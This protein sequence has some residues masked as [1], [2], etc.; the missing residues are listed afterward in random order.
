MAGDKCSEWKT[1]NF[2]RRSPV[3][4]NIPVTVEKFSLIDVSHPYSETCV[5]V[6]FHFISVHK[7][8]SILY[9]VQRKLLKQKEFQL[10]SRFTQNPPKS[11][12]FEDNEMNKTRSVSQKDVGIQLNEKDITTVSYLKGTVVS[13]ERKEGGDEVVK[14]LK[15]AAVSRR[16]PII[17]RKFTVDARRGMCYF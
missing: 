12:T 14:K 17:P 10:W 8:N 9:L 7:M 4:S 1:K 13:R 15:Y 6:D 5:E 3:N 16:P 11:L 2:I